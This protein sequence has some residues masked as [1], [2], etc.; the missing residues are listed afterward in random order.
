MKTKNKTKQAL[1]VCFFIISAIAFAKP[2]GPGPNA[3]PHALR[4]EPVKKE[5]P[6]K[7]CL[8]IKGKFLKSSKG[9]INTYTMAL[10]C[11]NT[12]VETQTVN[13]GSSFQFKI[14]KGNWW[15]I[16]ITGEGCV[17]KIYSIN[18]NLPK[19]ADV[20]MIY[21]LTFSASE[22]ISEFESSLMDSDAL[23]FPVAIF[24]FDQK[25]EAFNYNEEYTDNIMKKLFENIR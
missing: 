14:G 10:I 19:D 8:I 23:D 12:I 18:T 25:I 2:N 17:P 21:S 24:Q 13:C 9:V 3:R 16:K 20:D 1:I 6:S 22:P 11:E 5:K 4:I 7:A 15:A